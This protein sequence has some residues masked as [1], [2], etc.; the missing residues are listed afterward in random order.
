MVDRGLRNGLRP[1]KDCLWASHAVHATLEVAIALQ[2]SGFYA[3]A[4][5]STFV[6]AVGNNCNETSSPDSIQRCSIVEG[7]VVDVVFG[8]KE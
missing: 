3:S 4:R 8:E 6:V 2:V 7:E 1:V 5:L